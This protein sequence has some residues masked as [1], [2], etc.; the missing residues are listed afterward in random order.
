[1]TL[2]HLARRPIQP[3][4]VS[5]YAALEPSATKGST[6]NILRKH[7]LNLPTERCLQLQRRPSSHLDEASIIRLNQLSRWPY[8]F[9]DTSPDP[10]R[11]LVLLHQQGVI[12]ERLKRA[13][14]PDRCS[15]RTFIN[16]KAS[17]KSCSCFTNWRRIAFTVVVW[18]SLGIPYSYPPR[19]RNQD[20][21]P[22]YVDH[23]RDQLK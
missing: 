3:S 8:P 12:P 23:P 14:R 4:A 13:D 11:S 5:K 7:H 6:L 9:Q 2:L 1:V 20:R 21:R 16:T 10:R 19:S 17:R 15:T 22:L 18:G